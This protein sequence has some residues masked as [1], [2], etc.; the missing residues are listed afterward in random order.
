MLRRLETSLFF[1]HKRA[2]RKFSK[3]LIYLLVTAAIFL[4]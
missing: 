3:L 4:L 2:F 1:V